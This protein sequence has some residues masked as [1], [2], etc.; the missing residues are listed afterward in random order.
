VIRGYSDQDSGLRAVLDV[1]MLS[2]CHD[3]VI[4]PSSTYGMMASAL[5][6]GTSV[7]TAS[8]VYPTKWGKVGK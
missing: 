3:L 1:W 4:T 8:P 6:D 2:K 5:R 7:R